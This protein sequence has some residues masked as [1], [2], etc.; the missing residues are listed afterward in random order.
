MISAALF[1]KDFVYATL[2][3]LLFN[4]F[5]IFG[6][7]MSPLIGKRFGLWRASAFGFAAVFVMLVVLGLFGSKMPMWLAVIVPSLFILFHSSGPGRTARV[8]LRCRF[9][10]RFARAPTA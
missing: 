2:G 3:A 9:A 5:G 6:G 4:V 8:F 10:A 7:F 1:G